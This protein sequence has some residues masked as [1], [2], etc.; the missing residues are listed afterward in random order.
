[1]TSVECVTVG[2]KLN[3]FESELMRE[4]IEE[5]ID[6]ARGGQRGRAGR[7]CIVNTCTVTSKSDY[8]SRQAVR[9]AVKANPGALIIVTGC[10]AQRKPHE[11]SAIE[12]VDMVLGNA[13]KDLITEF[14]GLPREARPQVW[15]SPASEICRVA[16]RCLHRF[17]RYTRAFVKIQDGCNNRCSYCVVPS[18]RGP[19]RSKNSGEVVREIETLAD[20]GY[21]EVVLTGVHLGSYGQDLS[22][23][24]SLPSLLARVAEVRGIERIRLSS[25]EPTDFTD[26]LIELMSDPSSRIC[27]HVH[28]PLQSGDDRILASMRRPY[29]RTFYRNLIEKIAGA[30]PG[31]G[32]GVDVIVGYPTEDD[33]A[34]GNTCRL[35]EDLPVTYLHAFAFSER[36][37]TP[38]CALEPKVEPQAK[39]ERSRA[40]REVGRQKAEA[41]RRSLV[42]A[43][44]RV[45]VLGTRAEGRATGLSGNYVRVSLKSDEQPNS[46]VPASVTGVTGFGVSAEVLSDLGSKE[47]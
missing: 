10:Y 3:Q 5:E 47:A 9:R 13:E 17:G 2:C 36:E 45:L 33:E 22:P 7:V 16:G 19:S 41:F 40:I 8:R 1:M 30:V 44:L 34:F 21:R 37:G 14:I 46:I 6:P 35:I 31:C 24:T 32:I 27:P 38:A 43:T 39:R 28:V 4:A 25:V 15:V 11:V 12:G 26:S 29:G 42:G 18:V 23:A 20:S